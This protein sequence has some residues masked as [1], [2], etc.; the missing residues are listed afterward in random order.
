MNK[1]EEKYY[2]KLRKNIADWLEKKTNVNH[3]FRE[4]IMLVPDMFYLLAKLVQ[5]TEVPQGKKVKLISAIAYFI[6]PIDFLP[7]AF[8]GPVGYMDDLAIAAYVLNDMLNTVDLQIIRRHWAGDTDI[9]IIVKN[10][11]INAD[12]LMGK[13]IWDK[14]KRKF[15]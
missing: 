14:L 7:E 1:K 12:N 11:L 3:R 2:L 13:G 15:K 4:Y 9:L 5:D 6:S 10:I 8:L